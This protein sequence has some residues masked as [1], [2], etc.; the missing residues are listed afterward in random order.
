MKWQLVALL[1]VF[2]LGSCATSNDVV[3]GNLIT[4]R[5]YNK[6]FHLNLNK[7]YKSTKAEDQVLEIESIASAT[8][9][10]SS[11]IKPIELNTNS[12]T[13]VTEESIIAQSESQTDIIT[14]SQK[15]IIPSRTVVNT[16]QEIKTNHKNAEKVIKFI[17]KSKEKKSTAKGS[18]SDVKI[19]LLVILAFI[20]SPLAM[21]LA[22]GQTDV[23]FIVDLI[24]YLMLFSVFFVV[25]LYLASLAALALVCIRIF[26]M[27]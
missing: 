7:N 20:I 17:N 5:K 25:N 3:S 10:P 12:G 16:E 11:E 21:Y 4:K 2:I 23:W 19:V 24:F 13:R 18:N 15:E 14:D 27:I 22:D 9:E 8:I 1:G 6:G 26:G